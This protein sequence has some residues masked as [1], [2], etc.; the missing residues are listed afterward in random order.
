MTGTTEGDDR[1]AVP[2]AAAP[3]AE[4]A[5]LRSTVLAGR[6]PGASRAEF[7]SNTRGRTV[8]GDRPVTLEREA[9]AREASA[10]RHDADALLLHVVTARS[11]LHRD[12]LALRE[13]WKGEPPQLQLGRIPGRVLRRLAGSRAV[14]RAVLGLAAALAVRAL[15]HR[16]R[17]T[18]QRGRT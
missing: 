2:R 6:G 3:Q 17:R 1:N 9:V 11:L 8:V 12:V 18:G 10:A 14:R 15:W 4:I 13:R 16:G 7:L 5:R